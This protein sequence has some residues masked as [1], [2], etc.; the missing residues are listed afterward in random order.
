MQVQKDAV[1]RTHSFMICV[2]FLPPQANAKFSLAA[3]M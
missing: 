3:S 1:K 2:Y